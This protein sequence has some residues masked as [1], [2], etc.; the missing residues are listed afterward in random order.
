MRINDRLV[1]GECHS[2]SPVNVFLTENSGNWKFWCYV[3]QNQNCADLKDG[4]SF[5][6]CK[7]NAKLFIR[8]PGT[9]EWKMNIAGSFLM[10]S[11]L[12]MD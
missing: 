9:E 3:D 12:E 8:R 11:R 5:D 6:A 10:T 1:D 7:S 2:L 4:V